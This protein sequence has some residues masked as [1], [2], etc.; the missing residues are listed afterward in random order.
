MLTCSPSSEMAVPIPR[1]A[2]IWRCS[3]LRSCSISRASSMFSRSDMSWRKA[4]IAAFS[5]SWRLSLPRCAS[6][7]SRSRTYSIVLFCIDSVVCS[8]IFC[9]CRGEPAILKSLPTYPHARQSIAAM[10]HCWPL[11]GMSRNCRS[12]TIA[13]YVPEEFVQKRQLQASRTHAANLITLASSIAYATDESNGINL[14]HGKNSKPAWR[15]NR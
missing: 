6:P 8:G 11:V 10:P 12:Q 3:A 1:I 7:K 13:Q 4:S 5:S 9:C 15:L 14:N 2:A